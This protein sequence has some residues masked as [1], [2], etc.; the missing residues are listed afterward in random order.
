MV[1]PSMTDEERDLASQRLKIGFIALV[2]FSGALIAIQAGGSLTL[3]AAGFVSGLV[4]GA[5]LLWFLIRWWA[6]F[7]PA[8]DR[9]RR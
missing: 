1:G 7:L 4:L 2:A 9:G 3:V 5:V 6:E 8:P